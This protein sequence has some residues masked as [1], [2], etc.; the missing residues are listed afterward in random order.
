VSD[1]LL[2]S[3][4][5]RLL[6]SLP[7]ADPWP[8]LAESGFLDVLRPEADGGAGLGL[9]DLFVLALETGRRPNAPSIMETMAARL[10]EAGATGVD[11]VEPFL[12]RPLAAVLAAGQMVGS[13]IEVERMTTEYAQQRQQFGRE[14]SRFQAVQHQIAVL[15]EEVIAARIAAQAA[16]IGS[17][18]VVTEPRA[19]AAKCRVGQAAIQVSAIAHAVHGAIGVSAE[20]PLHRHTRRLRSWRLAHGGEGWWARRLGAW[21]IGGGQDMISAARAF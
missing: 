17:P 3:Q 8:A 5:G 16:F 12:G 20:H 7:A 19:A 10:V 14:I 18:R 11:D 21:A 1:D 9:E 2:L 15:A 4:Y 13:L 6:D